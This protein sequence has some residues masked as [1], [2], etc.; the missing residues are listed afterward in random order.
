MI[1]SKRVADPTY[2][3]AEIEANPVWKLAHRLSEVD[4]DNAPIGW[5][6]YLT[7]AHW[8]LA[9]FTMEEHEPT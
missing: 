5:G 1:P 2:V 7:L 6:Q 3:A 4:N 8:L 9:T